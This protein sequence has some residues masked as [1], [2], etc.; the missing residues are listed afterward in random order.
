MAEMVLDAY[1]EAPN[2]QVLRTCSQLLLEPTPT[3]ARDSRLAMAP[4]LV[5][6]STSC[7]A[8]VR[9]MNPTHGPVSVKQDTILGYAGNIAQVEET[10]MQR[11][12]ELE[13]D[14]YSCIRRIVP[15]G[16]ATMETSLVRRT[17]PLPNT[18]RA[19]TVDPFPPHLEEML[20]RAAEGR[21]EEE[22]D[23]I[24]NLLMQHEDVFSRHSAFFGPLAWK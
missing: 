7:T 24:R 4:T 22:M 21:S 12:N 16:D 19:P 14:N 15:R 18:D 10:V 23:Q 8:K 9:V 5:D 17:S 1:V 2:P 20:T 3:L 13:E 11:E 6:A